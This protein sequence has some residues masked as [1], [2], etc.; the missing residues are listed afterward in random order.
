MNRVAVTGLGV[1]TPLGNTLEAYRQGLLEG[2]S[3][4][5]TLS[6]FAADALPSRI[7]G[8]CTLPQFCFKD[9]K[10]DFALQA[11]R[12]AVDHANRSGEGLARCY[13]PHE[14]GISMGVGLELLN[15]PDLIRYA[16]S[17]GSGPDLPGADFLQTP[18]DWCVRQMARFFPAGQPASIHVSACAAGTDAIGD[19]YGRIARGRARIMLAGG[20][21]SMLNPLGLGGFCKL[22]ALSTRNAEPARAS[23]PFD[24]SRDGFVLGEGAA[25]LVLEAWDGAIRRGAEIF[26]EVLGYGTALDAGS[27]S[28]PDP[29]GSG[30]ARAMQRA[31]AQANLRPCDISYVN[32]HGTAT[33]KNDPAETRA[34]KSVFGDHA[35]ALPVSSTKS[36]IGHLISAAGAVEAAAAI[37]C[38]GAGMVHPTINLVHPDPECDLDY[39]PETARPAHIRYFM[40]NSFAFGGMNA[41][42]VFRNGRS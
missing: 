41:S 4:V 24:R 9:R 33:P 32:A 38:A 35:Y 34:I 16:A 10:V 2:R 37:L 13:A 20:A 7:A 11:A 19:A 27:I 3:G 12:A 31:L 5:S 30:A 21:D 28:E 18:G 17:G 42:L 26:A 36:M 15:M 14:R 22:N 1:V 40:S 23:R 8:Q 6:L 25:V 29:A 39:V